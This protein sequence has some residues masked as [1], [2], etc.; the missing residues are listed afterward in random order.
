MRI[1]FVNLHCNPFIIKTARKYLTKASFSPKHRFF[2]E[3][4]I[5]NDYQVA[6]YVNEEG[7]FANT[8]MSIPAGR[9]TSAFRFIEYRKI[10]QLSGLP[11]EK[12]ELIKKAEEIRPDDIVIL[13]N[14]FKNN[15]LHMHSI[16]CFKA[17]SM[18]H[19]YGVTQEA[20]R[21]E[22]TGIQ[23]MFSEGDLTKNSEIFK[24]NFSW[25]KGSFLIFPF[26]YQERFK[27]RKPFHERR[28]KAVA[29]GTLTYNNSQEFTEIYGSNVYQPLRK[30][31]L[32]HESEISDIIDSLI[33]NYN[34]DS[35]EMKINTGDCKIIKEI[36]ILYNMFHVGQQKK[37]F[38]FDMVEKFNEYK[39]C[40]VPE[41][42]Q[43]M[44]GIGFA[45]GMA[46]GCAYVGLDYS[47]Y[48][49]YGMIPGKHYI[50]YDGTLED[51]RK[52]LSYY[53]DPE[54][55]RELSDI[56][57]QGYRF[58]R[59][60]FSKNASSKKLIEQLVECRMQ[61]A[62]SY[63]H[64]K[65]K[66]KAR[67]F[68][69]IE[70]DKKRGILTKFSDNKEKF[71]G[72]ILWYLKLPEEIQYVCPRIF[73]YSTEYTKPYVTMEYYAYHT[74]H[75]LFLY[76]DLTRHQW[77]DIFQRI[78]F[79]FNEFGRYTIKNGDIRKSLE[80]MYLMKTLQRLE[81]MKCEE[82]FERFFDCPIT[83]NETVYQ[84]LNTIS[85]ML[86][87]MIPAMLYDVDCFHVI[88]GDLCFSNIMAGGSC[89]FIKVVDP[90]GRFGSYD[91]YGDSRYELAKLFHSVDGKYDFIIKD[92]F[93]VD[94]DLDRPAVMYS[95]QDRKNDFD[96]Y[97]IFTET[98]QSEIGNDLKKIELIEAL[99]F[100]SM[101]P[102]HNESIDHQLVM[103]A[104][105][106]DILSRVADIK[107][108][109]G[110]KEIV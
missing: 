93:E 91:I 4:L 35:N 14:M 72:E 84:P 32:D 88:H 34:E 42:I 97:E 23:A 95:I 77:D 68:N 37:Y 41:D 7:T 94:Y 100:L 33:S 21:L 102:L 106:L 78:R 30:Q 103:L 108:V 27:K 64:S 50:A 54:H 80:E 6:C 75:E 85:E 36:K 104:T 1:V 74:L 57:D 8:E 15:F 90:R 89:S 82:K 48:R 76:G 47:G 98:F 60:H 12:I 16:P 22:R 63:T 86:K 38:S 46:C 69:H 20:E 45:E 31:I 24:K 71:I 18:I 59:E 67:E 53:L 55:E 43:G 5:E 65:P 40:I 58:A 19:F 10:M 17:V 49:D 62:D 66:V 51:L 96:L 79:V 26:V 99:L 87:D 73:S 29:I 81:E 25:F 61:Y 44:P 28:N 2:L 110:G 13:Y 3:Y 52:K 92:L 39:I 101:I 105:G 83:V 56:A 9:L 109:Y 11:Y 107:A 70:I